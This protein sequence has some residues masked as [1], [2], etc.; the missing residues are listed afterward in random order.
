MMLENRQVPKGQVSDTVFPLFLE[1]ALTQR[2]LML[3]RTLI[4]CSILSVS[5][6]QLCYCGSIT[7]CSLFRPVVADGRSLSDHFDALVLPA[8][9]ICVSESYVCV[10]NA[11]IEQVT[12]QSLPWALGEIWECAISLQHT[13]ELPRHKSLQNTPHLSLRLENEVSRLA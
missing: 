2:F 10:W 11:C 1:M 4:H 9:L 3:I 13:G 12:M 7:L 6:L 8:S 5:P